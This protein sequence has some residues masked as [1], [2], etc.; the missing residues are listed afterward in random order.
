[1]TGIAE[2]PTWVQQVGDSR[3]HDIKLAKRKY[4]PRPQRILIPSAALL[5]ATSARF[6]RVCTYRVAVTS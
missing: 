1:M 4:M 3:G 6:R 5:D 2:S